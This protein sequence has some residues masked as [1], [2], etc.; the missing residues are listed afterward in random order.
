MELMQE[1]AREDG[2]VFDAVRTLDFIQTTK[3]PFPFATKCL[4]LYDPCV[5]MNLLRGTLCWPRLVTTA[6]TTNYKQGLKQTTHELF[7]LV[8]NGVKSTYSGRLLCN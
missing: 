7:G 1:A 3:N 8:K 4:P 6:T 5:S 2:I